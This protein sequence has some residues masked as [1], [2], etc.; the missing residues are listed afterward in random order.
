MSLPTILSNKLKIP[1]VAAPM[2]LA[3]GP[4]L[5]L[6]CCKA[7]IVGTFPAKNQRTLNGFEDWL[8]QIQ[9]GLTK[10]EAENGRPAPPFGVNL[11]AHRTNKTLTMELDLCVKYK[12]PLIITSLGAV[13]ELV[14]TVH[15]YGGIVFHDVIS[16]R[17]ARK[18]AADGVDGLIA[19]V[20][21]AGGHTGLANPFALVNEIRSFFDGTVLL[22]GA[23]ST[24]SDI[25]AAQMMGADLAYFGT[26]FIATKEC[27]SDSA[28]KQMILDSVLA[29]ITAT[30]AVSGI[31][32]NFMQ[33][34]LDEAGVD[35]AAPRQHAMI[36]VDKELDDAFNAD[37]N[38][39]KPW[40]DIWSAGHGVG[41]INDVPTVS[42]LVQRLTNQYHNAIEAQNDRL[43]LLA[44]SFD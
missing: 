13:P 7:G 32:A 36:D 3:S 37:K 28:Y 24:G 1:L 33:Q 17:H 29:N 27:Q 26:R 12:V 41:S 31:N 9:D 14:E 35:L 4:E 23:L 15:G 39:H 16:V 20:A 5:V 43:S 21:G 42:E 2:F 30:D 40:R 25:A 22:S 34:S 19:V 38:S 10:I 18:A 8:I 11:I 44:N 6:A